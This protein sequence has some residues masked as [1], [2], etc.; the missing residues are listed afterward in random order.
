M[1]VSP[2]SKAS[3]YHKFPTT[4]SIPPPSPKT[5]SAETEFL[6]TVEGEIS[7]FRSIMRARPVGLHRHF[8][9]LAIQNAIYKDTGRLLHVESIWH[10]LQSCYDLD[11]LDAIE[12]EA[13]GYR[14]PPNSTSPV[15]VRSPSP[16]EN[17]ARHPYF[18]EE[19]SLPFDEMFE[20][21]ISQRRMRA[22]ASA[23][24]SPVA[25]PT[26]VSA[27]T[28]PSRK[29]TTST[30]G[31]GGGK[32]SRRTKVDM[33][34]LV[35][36]DSDSSALTQESGDEA[37]VGTSRESVVTG[38]DAGTEF[39]EDEDVEMKEPSPARS[40]SPKPQRGRPKGVKKGRGRPS[41]PI[42]S[43]STTTTRSGKKRKR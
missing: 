43:T 23:P 31:G 14:L 7:F 32:R 25:S 35:G 12:L 6:A 21:L 38:T 42:P 34:G 40:V 16:S 13:E 24:S 11:A 18:R 19:Y 1:T 8:H 41:G 30:A 29:P 10:K 15:A 36:G 39:G 3:S 17:L 37:A 5:K 22:T 33:A 26:P 20:S 2:S 27:S 9:V 28:K 4:T